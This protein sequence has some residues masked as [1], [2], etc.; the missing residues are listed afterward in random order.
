[1]DLLPRRLLGDDTRRLA[2][3][4]GL[5]LL[6]FAVGAIFIAHGWGDATQDGGAGANSGNYR[7]AGIP[8]P[9]LSAWFGAYMQLIGGCAVIVGALTRLAAAGLAVV[10]AGALL[11]VHSG[12]PLVM[13]QDGSGSGFALSMFA[14][15]LALLGTGAGRFGVDRAFTGRQSRPT[16]PV[17]I[18]QPSGA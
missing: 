16:P 13:E 3:D 18:G 5:L 6:R 2:S 12:E 10:M 9:E 11:Y 8:L 4:T 17:G 7:D 1:M 15:S 14:A